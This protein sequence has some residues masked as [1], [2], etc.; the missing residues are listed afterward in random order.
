MKQIRFQ[1]ERAWKL[2]P[3]A[4]THIS[5]V[6]WQTSDYTEKSSL[7]LMVA[8]LS[9]ATRVKQQPP[10]SL[11]STSQ[12]GFM[13]NNL[14]FPPSWN[15]LLTKKDHFNVDI[16]LRLHLF[17][18]YQNEAFF[19]SLSVFGSVFGMDQR[20]I[21]PGN[22][23]GR[24]ARN[25]LLKSKLADTIVPIRTAQSQLEKHTFWT[26][27]KLWP[28]I[29]L[30]VFS[31]GCVCVWVTV[32]RRLT[33]LISVKINLPVHFFCSFSLFLFVIVVWSL[34]RLFYAV[35]LLLS[36]L[37]IAIFIRFP[38]RGA[39]LLALW[40]RERERDRFVVGTG[41]KD[42]PL[43]CVWLKLPQWK[44]CLT[45]PPPPQSSMLFVFALKHR[46]TSSYL[47]LFH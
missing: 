12:N 1:I 29:G 16:I 42:V 4:H 21:W 25:F 6:R 3:R 34:S 38:T 13:S 32:G 40:Q 11:P 45:P 23:Y 9:Y 7:I 5:R 26:L 41:W 8:A 19:P 33:Y 22:I 36:A 46:P 47:N 30:G 18:T 14:L 2:A 31:Y 43:I 44:S 24:S 37:K 28:G 10:M 17:R 39:I 27:G 20:E 35:H 15:A